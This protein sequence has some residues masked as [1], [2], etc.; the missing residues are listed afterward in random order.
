MSPNPYAPPAADLGLETLASASAGRGDFDIGQCISEAW[1]N[2]WSN[3]GLWLGTGIV[4]TLAFVLTAL[5]GIGLVLATPVLAWG[6]TYFS[7]RLHDGG[8]EFRDAFAGFSRYGKALGTMLAIFVVLFLINLAGQSIEIAGNAVGNSTLARIGTV[9]SLGFAFLVVPRLNFSYF[10][11]VD[12]D[13]PALESVRRSWDET[14]RAKWKVAGMMVL[15]VVFVFVGALVLIVGMIPA[16]VFVS[17]M[18]VSAYR[19]VFGGPAAA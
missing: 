18:W 12:R 14:G 10:L 4:W 19:Q 17:L 1:A 13:V 5:T 7:L 9:V 2:T 6:I 8:A 11:A 3:V 16:M 15:S